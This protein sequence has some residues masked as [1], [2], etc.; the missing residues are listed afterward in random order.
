MAKGL[1]RC[2]KFLHFGPFLSD[3]TAVPTQHLPRQKDGCVCGH[4]GRRNWPLAA[5]GWS[6]LRRA[7]NRILTHSMGP[8]IADRAL[9]NPLVSL[10]ILSCSLFFAH[11]SPVIQPIQGKEPE[12]ESTKGV[13][14][15]PQY[16]NTRSM[17]AASGNKTTGFAVEARGCRRKGGQEKAGA[18]GTKKRWEAH[19]EQWSVCIYRCRD[20]YIYIKTTEGPTKGGGRVKE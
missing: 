16:G 12:A 11:L 3:L 5:P 10:F 2:S 8:E 13:Q 14:P 4:H 1:T 19:L 7:Q 17:Q 6:W 15:T 18:G 20:I 9:P